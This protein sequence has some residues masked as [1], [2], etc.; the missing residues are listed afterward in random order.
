M[1][2]QRYNY[3]RSRGAALSPGEPEVA[4]D[5]RHPDFGCADPHTP[6]LW[7]SASG[8]EAE[9]QEENGWNDRV[10]EKEEKKTRSGGQP[11]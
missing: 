3:W 2:A 5:A 4:R 8:T 10:I 9:S 7:S 1:A 11:V 6:E